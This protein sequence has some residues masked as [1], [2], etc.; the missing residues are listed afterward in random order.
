MNRSSSFRLTARQRR[1][2]WEY[3]VDGDERAAAERAGYS[4]K[5]AARQGR[6]LLGLLPVRE[7]IAAIKQNCAP[8]ISQS[9]ILSELARIAFCDPSALVSFSDG[10]ITPA[11]KGDFAKE[12]AAISEIAESAS[13]VRI[14]FY[15]KL[16]AVEL[17]MRH[18]GMLDV[19]GS[20]GFLPSAPNSAA[21]QNMALEA[22]NTLRNLRNQRAGMHAQKSRAEP[23]QSP[24]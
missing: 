24:A 11:A 23:S 14:R 5:R 20:N 8:E 17:L 7:L 6:I 22:Q 18:K 12:A 1:F 21:C 9:R 19:C 4:P 15:D 13:G 10:R 3:L 16:K 2:A